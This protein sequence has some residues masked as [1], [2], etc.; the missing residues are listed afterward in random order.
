MVY[1]M[2]NPLHVVSHLVLKTA[3]RGW[4]YYLHVKDE[5]TKV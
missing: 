5:K 3:R 2:L 1:T 4:Y